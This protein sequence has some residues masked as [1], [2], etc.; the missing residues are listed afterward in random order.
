MNRGRLVV[1]EGLDGC[2]KSTQLAL[3]AARARASA[4]LD[5]LVTKE[6][7]DGPWG[8][9]IRAMARS[10]ELVAPE[11]ELRW[12]V[13][14]RREHVAGELRPGARP[15]GRIV[16]CDRYYLSTVAYQGA[17]GLDPATLLA[18]AEAEFPA[19]D[20]AFV[21]EI[22]AAAGLA[23][24]QARGGI[25]RARLRGGSLPRSASPPSSTRMDR[26]YLE[27]IDA[28]ESVETVQQAVMAALRERLG[29]P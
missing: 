21:F 17:R 26:P 10:G 6:P 19:P 27:R 4:G 13:E 12:F 2:G 9:K 15:R 28:R 24:V 5:V 3:A 23:R 18:Q 14:D 20:L 8:R 7:T 11:E 22:D 16:L 1:F 29:L 25:G